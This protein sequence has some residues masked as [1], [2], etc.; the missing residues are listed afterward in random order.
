[1]DRHG[2][3][4]PYQSVH[5]S[6]VA[7]DAVAL[8]VR[9]PLS[10]SVRI[11]SF[12][13][14]VA[15]LAR[16]VRTSRFFYY[17]VTPLLYE[18]VTLRSYDQIRYINGK[19][20]GYGSGS[21][22]SVGLNGLVT[23]DKGQY[24]KSLR[25]CG[26]WREHDLEDFTRGRVPDSSMM[27]NTVVRVAIGNMPRLRSFSWELNTK[28]MRA[29]YQGL[30]SCS[31]L[32]SLI[33]KFPSTRVPRPVTVVPP[34]PNLKTFKAIELD[35]LCYPDDISVLLLNSKKL[36]DLTVHFSPR[37]REQGEP[38]IN[39]H[40]IFGKCVL[41]GYALPVQ[42]VAVANMYAKHQAEL[43]HVINMETLREVVTINCGQSATDPSTVFLDEDWLSHKP[44]HL[45][46]NLK[47]L[48]IDQPTAQLARLMNEFSGLEC[49]YVVNERYVP[50]SKSGSSAGT[51]PG[52]SNS[53]SQVATSKA[54]AGTP[55]SPTSSSMQ[56]QLVSVASDVIAAITKSHG[57]S[58]RHLLL[59]DQWTLDHNVIMRI[60]HACPH[61]EQL[62]VSIYA[63][64]ELEALRYAL[65]G[66]PKL[67]ALR[68]L[69]PRDENLE[70][71][72]ASVGDQTHA[73]VLSAEVVRDH[74]PRLKWVGL[75]SRVF[76]V[77]PLVPNSEK[78][79]AQNGE[80]RPM[81]IITPASADDV[82]DVEIW[83]MDRFDV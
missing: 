11:I 67:V 78:K 33:I 2:S 19:P 61:L 60:V 54:R 5:T 32:T 30:A 9:F 53:D 42:R 3:G 71:H 65:M 1:M 34:M 17:L 35:P 83:S 73:F 16:L 6:P 8:F 7:M 10:V 13:D 49:L 21:P 56:E 47:V 63:N 27:L 79:R 40:A 12:V 24:V 66:L 41:A 18:R 20:E 43:E 23:G 70:S 77:G 72:L 39:V 38:S 51:T 29:V 59:S 57:E 46:K 68:I 31:G 26:E 25:L 15:D 48:R 64:K 37:M 76:K 80:P 69:F 22:F 44:H 28:P 58:I 62:G 50:Q 52:G 81:R 45:A 36:L 75:G 82:K 74:C 14:D 55:L 4:L